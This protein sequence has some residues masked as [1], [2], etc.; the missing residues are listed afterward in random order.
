ML[1]VIFHDM[2]CRVLKYFLSVC[3]IHHSHL[4]VIVFNFCFLPLG[5]YFVVARS[6]LWPVVAVGNR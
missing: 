3:T 4:A 1:A 2:C 6:P 5:L